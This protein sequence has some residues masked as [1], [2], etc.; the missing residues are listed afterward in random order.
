M[1][2][3]PAPLKL[4]FANGSD[5]GGGGYRLAADL[6][7]AL[8]GRGNRVAMAVRFKQ[9]DDPDV[10]EF[11]N[12]DYRWPLARLAHRA[13]RTHVTAD[14]AG[15]RARTLRH[16]LAIAAT[17][18]GRLIRAA[19]GFDDLHFPGTA[20]ILDRCPFVPDLLHLHI[21][22]GNYFDLRQLAPLS[23]RLPVVLTL[24]DYWFITGGCGYFAECE[25][26]RT[27]CGHC[28]QLPPGWPDRTH[29]NRAVK[30]SIY[31]RST[32][33]VTAPS[34]AVAAH[35]RESI[36]SNARLI[37]AVP[38]CYDAQ[39][40]A[41][42]DRAEARRRLNLPSDALVVMLAAQSPTKSKYKDWPTMLAALR[43]VG[44]TPRSP[45]VIALVLGESGAIAIDG[46]DVRPIP[47]VDGRDEL[48][49]HY[50]AAD[51]FLHSARE[52]TWGLVI[53]EAMACGTP[54]VATDVGGIP[55]QVIDGETG[56]LVPRQSPEA[57]A[58][59]IE[60][61]LNDGALRE[62]IGKV[63]A[64]H[65]AANFAAERVAERYEDFYARA[66]ADWLSLPH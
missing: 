33:Y 37:E 22:H 20:H 35:A 10:Y 50:A 2:P 18:P 60:R 1:S 52:E 5:S 38:N 21:G 14:N 58:A 44:R 4:L 30:A 11:R 15:S 12:D 24:H 64:R 34:R 39:V 27:T 36:L 25:R 62:R 6:V 9:L 46:L 28:P 51:L 47:F 17:E 54:V 57:F 55:D 3:S 63:A 29:E 43:Q 65:A 13:L 26:W 19:R 23:R 42:R 41:P 8:R 61:L 59:A 45:R 66:R 16:R 32:L 40:F 49:W 31:D 53:T 7:H 56:L 48:A